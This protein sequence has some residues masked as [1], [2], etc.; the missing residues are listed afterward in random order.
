MGVRILKEA[1]KVSLYK[2]RPKLS[3]SSQPACSVR[4]FFCH[5]SLDA[6]A[7]IPIQPSNP[8]MCSLLQFYLISLTVL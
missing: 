6:T 3:L 8:N 2:S 1:S 7:G 5:M 4:P